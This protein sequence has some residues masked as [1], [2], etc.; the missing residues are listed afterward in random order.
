M[1]YAFSTRK[2]AFHKVLS[3]LTYCYIFQ[4]GICKHRS[5]STKSQTDCNDV[6][7]FHKK[8]ASAA[9]IDAGD[10]HPKAAVSTDGA[11]SDVGVT[12]A[13]WPQTDGPRVLD[14]GIDELRLAA[15]TTLSLTTSTPGL[16]RPGGSRSFLRP[17]S[18]GS[19]LPNSTLDT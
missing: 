3:P 5:H 15:L 1:V 19:R 17:S 12:V 13:E 8:F 14:R 4:L 10:V 2:F 7:H 6:E 11:F 9:K 18:G 16:A